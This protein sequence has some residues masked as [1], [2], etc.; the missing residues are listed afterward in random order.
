MTGQKI[1]AGLEVAIAHAK[2]VTLGDKIRALKAT[3]SSTYDSS[4][5]VD[6]ALDRAAALAD[7][8]AATVA[9]AYEAAAGIDPAIFDHPSVYMGGP[10][11][12]AMKTAEAVAKAIRAMTDADAAA[13]LDRIKAEAHRAGMREAA[14][15]CRA[16]A[17]E[18][19]DEDCLQ[20]DK[21]IAPHMRGM[22]LD[23]LAAA[24]KEAGE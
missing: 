1:V 12:Q 2:S 23:I 22:A 13:A 10:S 19:D 6:L 15:M 9:A 4:Y 11:R 24:E 21:H 16:V 8:Y 18:A 5:F 7:A 3:V 14:A 20:F 17:D